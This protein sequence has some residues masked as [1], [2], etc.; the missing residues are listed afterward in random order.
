MILAHEAVL[1]SWCLT[2]ACTHVGQG[3]PTCRGRHKEKAWEK[4][5]LHKGQAGIKT[6]VTKLPSSQKQSSGLPNKITLSSPGHP[7]LHMDQQKRSLTE[8]VFLPGRRSEEQQLNLWLSQTTTP[9]FCFLGS[10]SR[11]NHTAMQGRTFAAS[12]HCTVTLGRSVFG[13]LSTF[14]IAVRVSKPPTT[15]KEERQFPVVTIHLKYSCS[16]TS[17]IS[18]FC[19]LPDF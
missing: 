6:E 5:G 17:N 3:T 11:V 10:S 8:F 15:L 1:N 2:S 13:S 14:S 12:W 18:N 19:P 7:P 9:R 4:C 16:P